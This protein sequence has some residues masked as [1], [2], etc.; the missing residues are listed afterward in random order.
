MQ[1]GRASRTAEQNALFRAL[2]ARRPPTERVVD[3][4]HAERFL[5]LPYRMVAAAARWQRWNAFATGFIDRRWPGVRPTV[6]ARTRA[7]DSLVVDEAAAV[8]QVV[9]LGAGL[10]TRAWRLE[11]LTGRTVFEVDYPDTQRHKQRR[12]RS[13]RLDFSRVRFVGADFNLD[14]LDGFIARAGLDREAPT[15][16]LWEGTTNYLSA[17]AVDATLRWCAQEP[18]GSHVIFTYIDRAVL[19]DPGRFYGAD[20]VLSTVRRAGEPMVFGLDPGELSS[21][22]ADRGLTLRSETGAADLRRQ[23]YGDASSAMRGHEFYRLA[24]AVVPN[25]AR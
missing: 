16:F 18:T 4:P 12:L 23:A 15:L 13:A 9:I 21:Y 14:Q 20:R 5:S 22:L 10:D 17:D 2:E 11:A 8:D 3:D 7:I 25:R 1:S 19:D 6:I 24:H